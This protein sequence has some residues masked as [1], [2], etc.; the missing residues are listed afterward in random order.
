MQVSARNSVEERWIMDA[1]EVKS[2]AALAEDIQRQIIHV[3]YCLMLQS[4]I[5]PQFSV[6]ILGVQHNLASIVT[7]CLQG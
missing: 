2:I 1:E 3:G 4:E 6:I 7:A 5:R